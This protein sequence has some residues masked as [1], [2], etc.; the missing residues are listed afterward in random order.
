MNLKKI[1]TLALDEEIVEDA[2][3]KHSQ[4][5]NAESSDSPFAI[6]ENPDGTT[7]ISVLV[8]FDPKIREEKAKAMAKGVKRD[9]LADDI[10]DDGG[11]EPQSSPEPAEDSAPRGVFAAALDELAAIVPEIAEDAAPRRQH[12]LSPI[13]N[14]RAKDPMFCPYH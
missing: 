13:E 4:K 3:K 1:A 9:D 14:C 7:T 8:T 2:V 5:K 11:G 6:E 10:P 12:G